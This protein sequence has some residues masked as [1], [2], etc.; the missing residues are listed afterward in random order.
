MKA[1]VFYGAKDFRVEDIEMPNIQATDVLIKVKA[2]GI[3]GSDLH[4]YKQGIFSRPGFVMGHE[5]S[6]EVTEVGSK[7]KGIKKGDRVI[8]L[9][10]GLNDYIE[11][12][13]ECFW[14]Q[15][16]QKHW[17]P[18]NAHKPCGQCEPR[19]EGKFW[20]CTEM[21]RFMLQGYSR[22]GGYAEYMYVPDAILD[23]N[24]FKIPDNISWEE[25]ALIE[26]LWGAY[27]W[28]AMADPQPHDVAVVTGL[29]TIGLLVMEVLKNYVS[30]V[31]V[32]EVSEKRLQ[33]AKSLGA[34]V[35]INALKEDPLKKV[36][37]L[38][39]AG[40]S[41]S[42]KHGACVDSVIEC[43]GVGRVL[44]QAIE[45]TR[46]GGHI[47]MVG[48]FEEPVPLDINHIIHKQLKLVSSFGWGK[49]PICDE[50]KGAIDMLAKGK[51]NVKALISHQFPVDKIM[52]AFEVQTKPDQSIKVLI[53][54]EM[55]A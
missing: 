12:C 42:G 53:R 4:A 17:C 5:L 8:P 6:G 3:C 46:T 45:M 19:K 34:D 52:E 55:K 48:L 10:V 2:C 30:K 11:G 24:I 50:I 54:P 38:T 40:R 44:Q 9:V 31:I 51:V 37:E 13:G 28:V 7:V 16:G 36:T 35:T 1:A 32:S 29:G 39:G 41:F 22:N 27:R 43:T 21:Q 23:K 26:P 20:L 25:A 18:N 15:R 14:C 33:L 47:V 49:E